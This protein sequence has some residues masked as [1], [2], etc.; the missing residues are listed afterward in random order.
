MAMK[1]T[2]YQLNSVTNIQMNSYIITT[3]DGCVLVIDGGFREDAGNMLDYL[4]KITGAAVPHVDAWILS[5]AHKDHIS[6]F[7]EIMEKHREAVD[8]AKVMYN[9]PSVQYC[10]RE[11]RGYDHAIEAFMTDLPL[12]ADKVAILYGSDVYDFG[13]AHIDVLYTQN[14]EIQC[15]YINNTSTIFMLTLGGKKILFTGDAG[16]EEGD[17][18]LALYAG[19][20][21]LKADYVQM[22][23]HGQNGV[24]REFYEA[25]APSACLWCTPDWLWNND[26]G[27]GYNTHCWQTIIVRGW[28][29]ELG[30]KEH[31]I[32]KDG[33]QIIDL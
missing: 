32:L 3:E 7:L 8:V 21:K 25:V 19:T 29:D 33:T 24:T 22:A 2:I 13:G 16:V 17:R 14:A 27:R 23:H 1:N 10:A 5:H 12:F 11:A 20:D 6:C 9:F 26:A 31:Y 15:N 18:C 4:R 30:V 28:M